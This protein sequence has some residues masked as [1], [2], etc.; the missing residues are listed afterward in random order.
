MD[1][2]SFPTGIII[3]N[4]C[5]LSSTR[6][7]N[8]CRCLSVSHFHSPHNLN[9]LDEQLIENVERQF[10]KSNKEETA[11]GILNSLHL[12]SR[13][14]RHGAIQIRVCHYKNLCSWNA[15]STIRPKM[16]P[17]AIYV[18]AFYLPPLRNPETSET[19]RN[20]RPDRHSERFRR[21]WGR[22]TLDPMLEYGNKQL[23]SGGVR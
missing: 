22:F 19:Q 7:D 21:L 11:E 23:L 14:T 16:D 9:G 20:H 10:L 8:F 2:Y 4:P 18:D 12:R 15:T 3:N 17:T 6:F 5:R 13:S 1:S